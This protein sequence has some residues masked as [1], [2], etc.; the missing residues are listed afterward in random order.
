MRELVPEKLAAPIRCRSKLVGAKNHIRGNG[1]RTRLYRSR[2]FCRSRIRV[3]PDL[4][5]VVSETRFHEIARA[6]IEWAT[7]GAYDIADTGRD[8]SWR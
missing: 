1:V 4:A 2:R 8:R 3:H 6:G 5:E 7:S